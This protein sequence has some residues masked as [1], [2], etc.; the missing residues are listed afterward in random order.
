VRQAL[1]VRHRSRRTEKAYVYWIRDLILFHGK[2]HPRDLSPEELA[3]YFNHLASTR[4]V[5]AS[6]HTQAL[7]AIVFLY[8]H[9]LELPFERIDTLVRPS[10]RRRVPVVLTPDEVGRV[11]Q[12]LRGTPHLVAALLYGSG[13]RLLECCTL[14]VHDIDLER[15]ELTVRN[16]KGGKDRRTMLP[17]QLIA[18]L[19]ALLQHGRRQYEDDLRAQVHVQ[20]PNAL[21]RKYP[22]AELDWRW[23]WIFPATRTYTSA[24][25]TLR[26]RHR[27]ETAIQRAIKQ[28]VTRAGLTKRASAHTF[29]HSFATHL[30]ER[31]QDIRTVQELLGHSDVATTQIY[32]HV[33]NRGPAAVLSPLD[34]LGR[35]DLSRTR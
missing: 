8:K 7:S 22:N 26:F 4:Q 3:A 29:R 30:L 11:L 27:H 10:R 25:T 5:S 19:G 2:R 14:R 6:T 21:R 18:P 20:V 23:R 24:G 13:I 16:G 9:V 28:A 15:R 12:E 35:L 31:G 32:T 33:L 17:E 1:R 34:V